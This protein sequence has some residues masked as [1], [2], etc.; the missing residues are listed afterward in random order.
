[1]QMWIYKNVDICT[2]ANLQIFKFAKCANVDICKCAH[3]RSFWPRVCFRCVHCTRIFTWCTSVFVLFGSI[4][5]WPKGKVGL[6][7]ASQWHRHSLPEHM[8]WAV[9]IFSG[10][11][12]ASSVCLCESLS[13]LGTV[14][15]VQFH[16]GDWKSGHWRVP[17]SVPSSTTVCQFLP[18]CLPVTQAFTSSGPAAGMW[19]HCVWRF[20]INGSDRHFFASL[21]QYGCCSDCIPCDKMF[22]NCDVRMHTKKRRNSC[23][24]QCYRLFAFWW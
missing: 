14:S 5:H 19:L 8:D 11:A 10:P 9:C 3:V 7:C 13:H 1:M 20:A 2:C 4:S 17:S 18:V 22:S 16:V 24:G 23:T 21:V 6:A 12:F 15:M